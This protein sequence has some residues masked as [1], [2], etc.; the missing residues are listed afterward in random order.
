[1][2]GY[3][4]K[5]GGKDASQLFS[6]YLN[7]E[8][9]FNTVLK[10]VVDNKDYSSDLKLLLI[11]YY[12][13]G[14]VMQFAPTKRLV[15]NYSAKNKDIS[16]DVFVR[17]SDFHDVAELDRWVSPN[18]VDSWLSSFSSR[19]FPLLFILYWTHISDRGMLSPPVIPYFDILEDILSGFGMRGVIGA[20]D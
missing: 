18:L 20:V 19:F 10:S 16:V 17:S 12:V 2:I 13:D 1:M 3:F 14:E 5:F 9:G 15:S 4:A 7:G 8:N 11:K 6:E